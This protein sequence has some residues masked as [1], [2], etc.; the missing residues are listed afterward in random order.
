MPL[1][2]TL[3]DLT[4]LVS[5]AFVQEV[6]IKHVSV[7]Q[8]VRINI[9]AFPDQQFLGTVKSVANIG[10]K[11]PGKEMNGFK[12]TIE[13]DPTTEKILP[14]MTTNNNI[15]TGTWDHSL[16]IPR[17]AVFVSDSVQYVFVKSALT[18]IKQQIET[19]GENETHFRVT[20]G[21]NKGDKVLL[22][23]PTNADALKMEP[24]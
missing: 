24:F 7:G 3:P 2:A 17:P 22:A 1:I 23:Q 19:G 11:M 12:V 10:Q 15:I 8:K 9:D 5:E 14:G 4:Q 20:K 13:I 16:V 21:L 18:T 6:D